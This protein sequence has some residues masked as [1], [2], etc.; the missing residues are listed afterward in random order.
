MKRKQRQP[1]QKEQTIL[2]EMWISGPRTHWTQVDADFEVHQKQYCKVI[3]CDT[4][5][6]QNWLENTINCIYT[7]QWESKDPILMRLGA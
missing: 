7:D 1:E 3:W 5:Q 4:Q 2:L 6:A